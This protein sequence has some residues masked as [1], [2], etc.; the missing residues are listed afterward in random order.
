MRDLKQ[1][2]RERA[3]DG[4]DAAETE[5]YLP[6]RGCP[7]DDSHDPVPVNRLPVPVAVVF[8]SIVRM[9]WSMVLPRTTT[10]KGW[11]LSSNMLVMRV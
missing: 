2:R 10:R 5:D 6:A 11:G 1:N 3:L 4:T 8:V 7:G 9:R